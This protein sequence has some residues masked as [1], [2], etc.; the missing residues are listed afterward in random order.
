MQLGRRKCGT[1]PGQQAAQ[2]NDPVELVHASPQGIH[3][4]RRILHRCRG[5]AKREA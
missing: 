5:K 3:P 2:P 4:F 1:P